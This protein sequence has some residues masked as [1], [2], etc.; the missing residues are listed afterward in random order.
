MPTPTESMRVRREEGTDCHVAALLAMTEFCGIYGC[1]YDGAFV[2]E[3]SLR[4]EDDRRKKERMRYHGE[5]EQG[6]SA[7]R[8]KK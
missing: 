3:G 8:Q 2:G 5:N 7:Q 4:G 1:A 6:L